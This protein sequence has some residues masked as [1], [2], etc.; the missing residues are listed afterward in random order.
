MTIDYQKFVREIA[1]E[2]AGRFP[3]RP[4]IKQYLESADKNLLYQVLREVEQARRCF[5][6]NPLS[7]IADFSARTWHEL[8]DVFMIALG[9]NRFQARFDPVTR[10]DALQAAYHLSDSKA[11]AEVLEYL[12][13][14]D[15]NADNISPSVLNA[16]RCIA[17]QKFYEE[18]QRQL[19]KFEEKEN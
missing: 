12:R 7:H 3:S 10:K 15:I 17:Q 19:I 6:P 5:N 16:K 4:V 2:H 14:E 13:Q 8:T 1:V 9:W 18:Y 11:S